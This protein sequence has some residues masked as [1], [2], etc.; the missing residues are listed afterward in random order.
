MGL[1]LG[2]PVFAQNGN[3]PDVVAIG[4]KATA[5]VEVTRPGPEG[6]GSGTAFCI[7]KS[8]LFITNA[9]VVEEAEGGRAE[10]RL[11]LETAKNQKRLVLRARVA[12]ADQKFD[13]ALLKVDPVP[14]LNPL[15]LGSDE[16]LSETMSVTT[17]GYPFGRT[18]TFHRD[19]YPDITVLES[20]ITS[21][22]KDEGR[23]AK[24]Q[25]DNQLNP[26]NSGGPVLG[27][28][29]K[30]VGVAQA[31]LKGAAMNFAVPVGQLQRFLNAPGIVFDPP[32][33]A[34]KDRAKPV[35]WTI[36]VQPSTAGR[37]L[38]EN[39]SLA[40][41]VATDVSPPRTFPA[42][43][44]GPGSFRVTLTPVP[45]QADAPVELRVTIG[46]DVLVTSIPDRQIR[47]GRQ[48][49]LL[50][51]LHHLVENPPRAT[52]RRGETIVGPI[53]GLGKAKTRMGPKGK[54]VTIDLSQARMIQVSSPAT[55][56]PLA[57]IEAV[58]ELKSGSE[59]LATR[60]LRM[61]L[62]G[63]PVLLVD[64]AR[65]IGVLVQPPAPPVMHQPRAAP[66][67]QQPSP[68]PVH[69]RPNPGAEDAKLVL[70]G[71]LNADGVPRG[72]GGTIKPPSVLM[73]DAELIGDSNAKSVGPPPLQLG[74][75]YTPEEFDREIRRR[76][77]LFLE[78]GAKITDLVVGGGGRYLVL[79]LKS[80]RQIALFDVNAAAIVKRID[81]PS[82]EVLVA[83]GATKLVLLYPD[84]PVL[85]VT[86]PSRLSAR[87]GQ[88]MSHQIQVLS[89]QGGVTYDLTLGPN[90][91]SVSSDGTVGWQIPL[92]IEKQEYEVL[93]TLGDASGKQIFHTIRIK[94]E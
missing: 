4:K 42:K 74:A 17:F 67:A 75:K 83:A 64:R 37:Q 93:L 31:T 46:N 79:T 54:Q 12:R 94:I 24:I 87:P 8:G 82:E 3:G 11:V 84:K 88:K 19:G 35:T 60:A 47:V 16:R 72:A 44:I 25:F 10:V 69:R 81:L 49:F 77:T 58:V 21:L 38:P 23:L 14:G 57:A 68:P 9:H 61:E 29:G 80:A 51:D 92:T 18:M 78:L 48:A 22:R 2:V 7:D 27:P 30:V 43:A 6:G 62:P 91:I 71:V 56:K 65:G 63:A 36:K 20:R 55:A 52:T 39:L 85:A 73:V 70:G 5:L 15:A 76:N 13:L 45:K 53:S 34:Y 28:D 41:T 40:V 66:G 32:A 59:V 90:G 89:S 50:S 86:S 33:L 26:G 1:L